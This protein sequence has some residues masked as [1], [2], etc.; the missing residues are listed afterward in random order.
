VDNVDNYVNS[1]EGGDLRAGCYVDNLWITSTHWDT[2]Q[3]G[4]RVMHRVMHNLRRVIHTSRT[5][6]VDNFITFYLTSDMVYV[7]ISVA[8]G[9]G[10]SDRRKKGSCWRPGY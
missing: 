9:V 2:L 8:G 1:L 3:S 7:M 6:F 10:L 5:H 4:D